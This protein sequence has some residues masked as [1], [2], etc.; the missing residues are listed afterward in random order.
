MKPKLIEKIRTEVKSGKTK[1]QVAQELNLSYY[2]VKKYTKDFHTDLSI[3]HNLVDKIR[4]EVKNGK[5]KRQVAEEFGVSRD[6]IINYT[7]DIKSRII[8]RKRSPEFIKQIRQNVQKYNSK[9]KTAR[10]MGISYDMVK[11]YTQDIKIKMELPQELKEKITNEILSGKSK[12]Q[13]ARDFNLSY[14]TVLK[15]TIDIPSKYHYF[16]GNNRGNP[17]IRGRTLIILKNLLKNGYH[18]CQKGDSNRYRTLKK[19]FPSI[20]KVHSCGKSI[21]F[22]EDKSNFAAKALI[23]VSNKKIISYQEL[24]QITKIFDTKLNK[25]EK[26][27]YISK[28]KDTNINSLQGENNSLAFFCIRKYCP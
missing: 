20:Y 21:I 19:Y 27:R 10:L 25:E 14:Q 5:S 24:K 15:S 13:T 2:Q 22:L 6:T 28:S 3:P 11:W 23:E 8:K 4:E 26:D 18:H 16:V 9:S 7:R 12:V 17:G 1:I